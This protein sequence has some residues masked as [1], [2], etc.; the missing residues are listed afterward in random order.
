LA[1]QLLREVR[2]DYSVLDQTENK[3]ANDIFAIADANGS[4]LPFM[5]PESFDLQLPDLE[6][7]KIADHEFHESLDRAWQVCLRS[8]VV[9]II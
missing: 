5:Q 4:S 3:P 8:L 6:D 2:F 7:E 1:S 9:E